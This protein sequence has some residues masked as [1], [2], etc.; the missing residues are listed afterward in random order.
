MLNEGYQP[1][2]PRANLTLFAVIVL[3][4]ASCASGPATFSP[5]E[6]TGLAVQLEGEEALCPGQAG[7]IHVTL[8]TPRGA[9]HTA[10]LDS[11]DNQ[12]ILDN[13]I[14]YT[15]FDMR[16]PHG[17]VDALGR[18]N[19]H[20]Q[21]LLEATQGLSVEVKLK[22]R[23]EVEESVFLPVDFSCIDSLDIQEAPYAFSLAIVVTARDQR[24]LL[25]R[26]D[27]TQPPAYTVFV[28]NASEPL[29]V[30]LATNAPLEI[31][32]P[33]GHPELLD[34]LYITAGGDRRV[35]SADTVTLRRVPVSE[36]FAEELERGFS[37]E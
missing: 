24:M 22:A 35:P 31:S 11:E 5:D 6:V 23:P 8:A 1:P 33:A 15:H 26:N 36:L 18:F 27:A 4:T 12:L 20:A 9:I 7:R 17:N 37:I 2:H 3:W 14:D 16:S 13:T 10:E 28:P 32:L 21:A 34:Y 29:R 30:H 19:T 25:V